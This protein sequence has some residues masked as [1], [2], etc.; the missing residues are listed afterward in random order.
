[1]RKFWIGTLA[2][3]LLLSLAW[4]INEYRLAGNYRLALDNQNQSSLQGFASYLD[5]VDTNMAKSGVAGT[6]NQQLLY[7]GRVSNQSEAANQDLAQLPADPL[8]LSYTGQLLTQTADFAN[9]LSQRI[10]SG[11]SIS[12]ADA[13]TLNDMHTRLIEVNRKVQNLA[14]QMNTENLPWTSAPAKFNLSWLIGKTQVAEASAAGPGGTVPNSV[15]GGFEQLD[16]SLEKLPPFNYQGEFSTRSVERPLGLPAGEVSREQAQ[17]VAADFLAK[18]GYPGA[19]P[20]AA[21]EIRGA[22]GGFTFTDKTAYVDVSRQGGVVQIF[23]DQRTIQ[24]R[25]LS[26]A[27]AKQK[28]AAILKSMH[29][30]LTFTS[31]EDDG[32]YIQLEAVSDE[33]GILYYP[34]K[35]RLMVAM[36][37]GQLVGYDATSY[38]AFH[39]VRNFPGKRIT[40]QEAESKLH[41]GFSV[42]SSQLVVIP[43]TGNQEALCYE[44]RGRYQG[45]EYLVYVNALSGR[46]EKI[47]RI[48]RTPRGEYVQ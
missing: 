6:S 41:S 17:T 27:E 25:K 26:V 31:V 11:G 35:V 4:G 23:R 2:V 15:R 14:I 21:G 5:Q 46:E 18:A 9:S 29:W 33:N 28:A 16:S 8:G 37:N 36:D 30:N 45:E 39:H 7:L 43:R 32:S 47:Q 48:I 22:F 13:K 24:P 34:D 20:V 1:M 44:F 10:A 12:S 38:W 42:T 40:L 19:A 3:A